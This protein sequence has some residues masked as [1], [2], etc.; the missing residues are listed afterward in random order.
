MKKLLLSCCFLSLSV[1]VFGQQWI[2]KKYT[3]D[4]TYNVLYGTAINFN[5]SVD[6]LYMD[7]YTP[8]CNDPQQ[9]SRRPLML[10]IHGGAFLAGSKNDPNIT[11]LCKEFAKR[12]YVTATISYR[13]GFV[14]D[15]TLRTCNYPNYSCVFA[16]DTAEW[17]RAYYR[18]VQDGK[19]ALR[20]LINRN[21]FYRIDTGNV[22]VAGESAGAITALGVA[23][24]DTASEKFSQAGLLPN[25]SNPHPATFTCSY[26]VGES[27]SQASVVRPD[28]GPIE[29]TIEPTTISYTI[30]GVGN[31]YGAILTDILQQSKVGSVKPAIYSFHQPCDIVVPI[32]AGRVYEGLSWCF[33]NGYGCYGVANTP[34]VRGSR[35]I[36]TLNTTNNYGYVI[37]NEFTAINFPY[38]FLFGPGSCA[39]QVNNPCHAFDNLQLREGNMAAFFAPLITTFPI[40]DTGAVLTNLTQ[41]AILQPQVELIPNPF[42]EQLQVNYVGVGAAVYTLTDACGRSCAAG[43]VLPGRNELSLPAEL[44]AGVYLFRLTTSD[45]Q[46]AVRRLI[47]Y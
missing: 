7:I 2:D 38:S 25:V 14:S 29:G 24:L 41:E 46:L 33:T 36:S 34:I 5:G 45:G 23:L 37:Q 8:I 1:L 20:Y 31:N 9:V 39:D 26:A 15:D 16:A 4:S 43:T 27:F 40:C 44:P 11:Y 18:A 10:I 13:L 32:D 6:S 47:H 35:A 12:G 17:Y 22:F 21:Q 28:L 30:K 19:G 3:Y 42:H